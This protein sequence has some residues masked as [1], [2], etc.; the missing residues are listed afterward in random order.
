M[1][2]S[3]PYEEHMPRNASSRSIYT[4]TSG[5][6]EQT[7]AAAENIHSSTSEEADVNSSVVFIQR[8][9]RTMG[10]DSLL[11]K[12][13]IHSLFL[14]LTQI[15]SQIYISLILCYDEFTKFRLLKS[16]EQTTQS[17]H[18]AGRG[19]FAF[20]SSLHH[21]KKGFNE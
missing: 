14:F 17:P 15:V 9:N 11:R 12:Y 4:G 16:T 18:F 8:W 5:H 3:K 1:S 19:C 10:H 13:L 6:L 21:T 7:S 2:S 20:L